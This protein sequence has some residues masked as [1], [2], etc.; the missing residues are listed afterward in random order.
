[1]QIQLES[2]KFFQNFT[3]FDK[4]LVNFNK[5]SPNWTL[6]IVSLITICRYCVDISEFLLV[7][8]LELQ[9]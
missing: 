9:I 8:E 1:M 7:F 4:T 5:F 6:K 3:Q 2:D